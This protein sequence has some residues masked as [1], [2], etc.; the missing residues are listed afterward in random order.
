[1]KPMISP[2]NEVINECWL[3]YD[4]FLNKLN[5]NDEVQ[6]RSSLNEGIIFRNLKNIFRQ[7]RKYL[8]LLED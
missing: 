3:H 4:H 6:V 7:S 1:M 5:W 2:F 8:N